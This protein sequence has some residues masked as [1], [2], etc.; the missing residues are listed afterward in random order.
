MNRF[1]RLVPAVSALVLVLYGCDGD[2][3]EGPA[4]EAP[5]ITS[6]PIQQVTEDSLFTFAVEFEDADGP[7]TIVTFSGVPSWLAVSNDTVS[8]IPGDNDTDTGFVVAV[9]DGLA[10]DTLAVQLT[11]LAVNDPPIIQSQD[12][13]YA[14]GGIDYTFRPQISDPDNESLA[15]TFPHVPSW[16]TVQADSL[17][18]TPSDTASDDSIT[19]IVSDGELTDTAEVYLRVMPPLVVYGDSRTGHDAHTRVVGRIMD[20]H[21][22]VV[23]HS[24]DLVENGNDPSDWDI[25]NTITADMRAQAEFFP[26]LGNHE[27]QSQLFFDNF[28]LPGNEQWYSVIRNRVL[29]II[30]NSCVEIGPAS[31]QYQWLVDELQSVD[32]SV[33]YTAVIF[34]HPPYSTGYHYLECVYYRTML[35]PVFEEYGVDIVFNGHDHDY[36]RSF[37]GGI[38]YIVAGGGGAPLRDQASSYICSQLFIRQYHF[39]KVSVLPDRIVVKTI[40]DL[41]EQLDQFEVSASP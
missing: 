22:A 21:P 23:F 4:N 33:W 1:S 37:C 28:E 20:V 35:V 15:I 18:G 40:N 34:H 27:L 41:G 12:T 38:Y 9:S 13:S 3:P 14:S 29:F 5:V 16:A 7:D 17:Y 6:S 32:D 30:L 39:C 8:G 11:V 10:A 2:N 36:E 19:V 26:A 24:G 31:V 25:F